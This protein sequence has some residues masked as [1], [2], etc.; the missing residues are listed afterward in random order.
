M[1]TDCKKFALQCVLCAHNKPFHYRPYGL[2]Q[3]LLVLVPPWYSI[4]MEFVEH[5]PTSN[6]FTDPGSYWLCVQ[7]MYFHSNYGHY[8][9][10]G[11]C[12]CTP[13][14]CVLKARHPSPCVLRPR[15]G[16]RPLTR[17]PPS[18]TP[19]LHVRSPPLSQRSGRT[20][21]QQ[22]GTVPSYV[23]QLQAGQLV[24]VPPASWVRPPY[25]NGCIL[26][27]RDSHL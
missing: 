14:P 13:F 18:N 1:R 23:L 25:H 27:L 17:L 11:R 24:R 15:I 6:G 21:Q 3:P 10:P 5:L 19:T 22:L 16:I 9:C 20:G 4:S 26:F 2:L 12:R 8:Y 7:V